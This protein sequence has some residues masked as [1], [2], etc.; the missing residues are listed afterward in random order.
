M[1]KEFPLVGRLPKLDWKIA[2]M[3]VVSTTLILTDYYFRYLPDKSLER[4]ITF[5]LIPQLVIVVI[6]RENPAQ[7]GMQLGDWRAGLAITGIAILIV[8]P[9]LW[10]AVRYSSSL[11]IYY[12]ASGDPVWF[13][14][15]FLNLIGWEFLFRGWLLFGYQRK[16]G[17]DAIWLQAVPFALAHLTKPSLETLSTIFGGF[18]FGWIAWRTRSFLYVFII[19]LYVMSFTVL[20]ATY[21]IK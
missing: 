13:L 19:H 4:L 11:Q 8:T 14:H 10:L 6:F 7:N 9:I 5:L 17:D 3:T 15:E 21:L 2:V 1:Q 18:L 12:N 20:L 16:F